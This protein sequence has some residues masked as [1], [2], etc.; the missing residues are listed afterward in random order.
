MSK[1]IKNP[2]QFAPV[3]QPEAEIFL[4]GRGEVDFAWNFAR[5]DP[6]WF[7]YCNSGPGAYLKFEDQEIRPDHKALEF[8]SLQDGGRRLENRA[9]ITR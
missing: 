7:L 6:F 8:P 1:I 9:T 5:K 4:Y 2:K 3:P